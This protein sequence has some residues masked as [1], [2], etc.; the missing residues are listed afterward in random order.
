MENIHINEDAALQIG[1]FLR[2]T[3]AENHKFIL[4]LPTWKM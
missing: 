3:T 4:V 1:L 2:L